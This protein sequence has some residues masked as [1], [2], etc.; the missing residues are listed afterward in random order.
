M[1]FLALLAS[2]LL[3]GRASMGDSNGFVRSMLGPQ[4]SSSRATAPIFG[5]GSS[6]REHAAK[7]FISAEHAKLSTKTIS[8]GPAL[9]TMPSTVGPQ[10]D[11]AFES[12]PRWAFGSAQRFNAITKNNLPGPGSYEARS[13]LGVQGSSGLPTQ[14]LYGMGTGTRD[15]VNKLYISEKHSTALFTG[16]NSPGPATYTLDASVGKQGLSVKANQPKWVFGSSQ[17]FKNA[18][19]KYQAALPAPDA[20]DAPNGLGVQY[21]SSKRSAPLPGFGS[22]T[23]AHAS[24]VFMSPEHEKTKSYGRG[25]PGPNTYLP[26]VHKAVAPS[27]GFGTCDRF[28]MRKSAMRLADNP[29]PSHYN[30]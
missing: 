1:L 9:Y 16:K 17:R 20:Y 5:F 30:V 10:V 19:L 27:F 4:I 26:P 2:S 11:G 13:S 28:Y 24:K 18:D 29:S 6:T 8:P 25:S 12:A 3:L 7:I 15:T 23:R 22:S 14:P 21:S